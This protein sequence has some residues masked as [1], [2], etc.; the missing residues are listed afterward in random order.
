MLVRAGQVV[1]VKTSLDEAWLE[2][3]VILYELDGLDLMDYG[4]NHGPRGG[5]SCRLV[6]SCNFAILARL[7][8]VT[9]L[10]SIYRLLSIIHHPRPD[11]QMLRNEGPGDLEYVLGVCAR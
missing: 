2:V 7:S 4:M 8:L 5:Q 11:H 9:H 1:P 3:K 10:I 6:Q